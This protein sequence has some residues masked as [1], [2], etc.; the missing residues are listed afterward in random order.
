MRKACLESGFSEPEF[1][2]FGNMIR[3]TLFHKESSEEYISKEDMNILKLLNSRGPLSAHQ[4]TDAMD[5]SKRTILN[6]ISKLIKNGKIVEISQGPND[7]RKKYTI[8]KS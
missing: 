1:Q 6:K 4:I 3:V 5:L 2:E 7:P 8:F